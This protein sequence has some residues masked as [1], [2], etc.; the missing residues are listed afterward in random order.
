LRQKLASLEIELATLRAEKKRWSGYLE[1]QDDTGIDSPY[2]L[3]K[4]LAGERFNVVI[5]KDRLGSE[6][7]KVKGLEA[8]M[9]RINQEV[10]YF[11]LFAEKAS[12]SKK[13]PLA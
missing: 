12:V 8:H 2:A 9:L 7:A 6:S 11:S 3:S 13:Y 5:L 10:D 1:R 4:A